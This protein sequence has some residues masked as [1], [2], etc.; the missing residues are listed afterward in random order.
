MEFILSMSFGLNLLIF[1]LA[2]N[3][4]KDNFANIFLLSL[5]GIVL[6]GTGYVILLNY[7]SFSI[8]LISILINSLPTLVGSLTY[9]YVFY[10]I[11]SLKKLQPLSLIHLFPILPAMFL[12]YFENDSNTWL[13]LIL[14]IVLK[15]FVSIIY[16]ALSIKILQNHKK[17][18]Q[19]HF[20]KTDVIDLKWLLFI[21]KAGLIS[22]L[23]YLL[24]MTLW[25]LNVPI[26]SNLD[27]YPNFIVLIFILSISYYGIKSTNVFEGITRLNNEQNSIPNFTNNQENLDLKKIENK[28]L[29]SNEKANDI[30]QKIASIIK[31]KKLYQNENLMIEDIAKELDIHSK[32]ISYSI[33]SISGKNF[34]D[35]INHFRVNEFNVEVLKPEN[36]QFTYL[37]IAFNSGFGSKSA[38]NRAYKNE[39]GFSPSEYIKKF[40]TEMS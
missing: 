39:M 35:F 26:A 17:N 4:R 40:K 15:I 9:L 24:I 8:D 16:F 12:S 20:S 29:I 13:T 22:Y 37:T 6:I 25:I 33:N 21:V 32:Y 10:T 3:K 18:I 28:E 7:T 2:I 5:L 27:T 34:F 23:I 19:N 1:L 31:S 38:F 14:N 36:K 11:H 30:Y